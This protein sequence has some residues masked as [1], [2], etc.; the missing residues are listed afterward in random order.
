[1]GRL[2]DVTKGDT[3]RCGCHFRFSPT[4]TA[5]GQ[6]ITIDFSVYDTTYWVC[7]RKGFGM[8]SYAINGGDFVNLWS[9]YD[10]SYELEQN[11]R[12][13][14]TFTI[15]ADAVTLEFKG[16]WSAYLDHENENL[17]K[18]EGT[19]YYGP[20][21][22]NNPPTI[23]GEDGNLGIHNLAFGIP[24]QVND[25][26]AGDTLTVTETLN[27]KQLR[28][29]RSAQRGEKYQVT[30]SNAMLTA[31]PMNQEIPVEITVSDS[32]DQAVRS[33][34]FKKT[35]NPEPYMEYSIRPV[36][37][38]G[39]AKR[40]VAY[41]QTEE[42]ENY[43]VSVYACNN[44]FD[45][46]PVWEEFSDQYHRGIGYRFQNREKAAEKWGISVRFINSKLSTTDS[47]S[48]SGVAFAVDVPLAGGKA[49]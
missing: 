10:A 49:I 27:G 24:Y 22:F 28:Q 35:A 4:P 18:S 29:I 16:T 20:Y 31:L 11:R 37:T 48:I 2:P 21:Y 36:E 45:Q 3:D 23:S 33:Y 12:H 13:R 32:K 38:E 14:T 19:N 40:I 6:T 46:H 34:V 42:S 30:I 5:A 8:L 47:I 17:A 1:M 15:P 25:L 44:A 43:L 39:M 9:A 41:Q 26:D 7:T